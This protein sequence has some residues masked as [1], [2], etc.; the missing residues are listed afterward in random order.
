MR[1][2]NRSQLL[3]YGAVAA[4]SVLFGLGY[5]LGS[6][7]Q[8]EGMSETCNSFWTALA[9]LALNLGMSRVRGGTAQGG[10]EGVAGGQRQAPTATRT[11][12]WLCVCCGFCATWVSNVLFMVAYRYLSVPEATML[13]FLHPSLVAVFMALFFK[14]RFSVTRLLAIVC[15]IWSM[16]LISGTVS[17]TSWVGILAAVL[18]GVFYAVYP[19]M[20]EVTPLRDLESRTVVFYMNLTTAVCG[21]LISLAAGTFMLPVSPLVWGC[22]IILG[23]TNFLAYLLSNYAVHTLGATNTSFGAMLEPIASCVIAA[24]FLNQRMGIQILYAGVLILL[25]VFFCSRSGSG[26]RS[27]PQ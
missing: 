7:V 18:T 25:S 14:E 1:K 13:H 8:A 27:K 2:G 16:V 6:I 23:I 3:G 19:V 4:A 26:G 9:A 20:V 24:V 17:R 21:L 12:I 10:S 22:D 15:S 5:S 11:Q